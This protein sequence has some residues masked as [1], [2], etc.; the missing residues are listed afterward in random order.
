MILDIVNLHRD[1]NKDVVPFIRAGIFVDTSVMKIYI[2]GLLKNKYGAKMDDEFQDVINVLNYLKIHGYWEKM[3]VTPHI[4]T[5][6]CKHFYTDKDYSGSS[7]N[8]RQD[9]KEMVSDILPILKSLREESNITKDKILDLIDVDKPVIEI[10][11]LSIFVSVNE[12]NNTG[13]K[14]AILV[15]DSVFN[16][17]YEND[18]NIMII[19]FDKTSLDIKNIHG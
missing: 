4:L 15:K 3:Y 5:E 2:D 7:R 12:L 8:K 14:T 9:F 11:D 18:D 16:K 10:G 17:K 1:F 19:D 6:I 13:K